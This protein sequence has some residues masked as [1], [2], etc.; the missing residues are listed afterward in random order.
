MFK[1]QPID[2]TPWLLWFL[3]KQLR[4]WRLGQLKLIC[5]LP[6][7]FGAVYLEMS[8]PCG[9]Y[10]WNA[11]IQTEGDYHLTADGHWIRAV[12][13]TFSTLNYWRV[14]ESIDAYSFSYSLTIQSGRHC[15][16][17]LSKWHLTC[18]ESRIISGVYMQSISSKT[19]QDIPAS[20]KVWCFQEY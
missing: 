10:C 14:V 11:S 16:V 17:V 12:T 6:H 13:K 2:N 18:L 9:S 7:H 4:M 1:S 15:S 19:S 5:L 20:T 8:F 3:C